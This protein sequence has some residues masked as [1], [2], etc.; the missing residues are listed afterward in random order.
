MRDL[1]SSGWCEARKPLSY[2]LQRLFF[3]LAWLARASQGDTLQYVGY[4][5]LAV[6]RTFRRE[7]RLPRQKAPDEESR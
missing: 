4:S 6:Q 3:G 2:R 7:D 1:K 5:E